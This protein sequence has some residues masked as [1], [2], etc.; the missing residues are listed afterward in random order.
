MFEKEN[1]NNSQ[2]ISK[3]EKSDYSIP[4]DTVILNIY[5]IMKNINCK[6]DL[7]KLL[8]DG[9]ID[10]QVGVI[11]DKPKDLSL[12]SKTHLFKGEN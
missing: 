11:V 1:S 9:K 4:C 10:P 2:I 12:I 3:R 5:I 7:S 6:I 8:W